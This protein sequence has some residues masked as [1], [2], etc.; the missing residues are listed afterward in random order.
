MN[1]NKSCECVTITDSK[2]TDVVIRWITPKCT[3]YTGYDLNNDY[4]LNNLIF[5]SMGVNEN[6]LLNILPTAL[7]PMTSFSISLLSRQSEVTTCPRYWNS[8][9]RLSSLLPR[10][11]AVTCRRWNSHCRIRIH[12]VSIVLKTM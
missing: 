4:D 1:I 7:C 5:A 3:P 12:R 9:T 6:F 10:K 2:F 11:K 8:S